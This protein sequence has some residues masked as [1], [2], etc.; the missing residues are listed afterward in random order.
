MSKNFK[1]YFENHPS[2]ED[3]NKN[4]NS[5]SEPL[6]EDKSQKKK[7]STATNNADSVVVGSDAENSV[8]I[9]HSLPNLG[10]NLLRPD[11]NIVGAVEMGNNPIGVST[12]TNSFCK[13]VKQNAP[14]LEK[15]KECKSEEE[16]AALKGT[17]AGKIDGSTIFIL[18][19]FMIKALIN[20]KTNDP[21]KLIPIAIDAATKFE[22]GNNG[23]NKLLL[24]H[25]EAL[26]NLLWLMNKD[27][28]PSVE[29]VLR[30]GDEALQKYMEDG[31]RQCLKVQKVSFNEDSVSLDDSMI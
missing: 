23:E 20:A 4:M 1:D 17:K 21:L 3:G 9:I 26:A 10:G 30:P 15:Y 11:D 24:E 5:L 8:V 28:V 12:S 7:T 22:D 25:A 31:K 2:N 29:F 19:P 27:K 18:A 14:D 6:S 16:L 13:Q